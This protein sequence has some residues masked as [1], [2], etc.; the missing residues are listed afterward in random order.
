MIYISTKYLCKW[1]NSGLGPLNS[2]ICAYVCEIRENFDAWAISQILSVVFKLYFSRIHKI[3]LYQNQLSIRFT[4]RMIILFQSDKIHKN[5]RHMRFIMITKYPRWNIWSWFITLHD[6][7]KL[8]LAKA[9]SANFSIT[10]RCIPW[11]SS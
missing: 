11:P 9:S 4:W 7:F 3:F 1:Y 8:K 5:C 6:A 2:K 10:Q